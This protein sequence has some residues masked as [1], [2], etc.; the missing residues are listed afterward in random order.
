MSEKVHFESLLAMA[1]NEISM[2]LIET[3]PSHEEIKKIYAASD[4]F[5]KKKEAWIRIETRKENLI[6]F[7]RRASKVAVIVLL[8]FSLSFSTLLTAKAVRESIVTTVLEWKDKFTRIFIES[9]VQ[10]AVLPEIKFNY[11]P[12]GFELI[13]NQTHVLQ[14]SVTFT[15]EN[16]GNELFRIFITYDFASYKD[17]LDNE[18]SSFY[19]IKINIK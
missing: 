9:D 4:S 18:D 1:M 16:A 12:D 11:I 3:I 10:I 17:R 5:L 6:K 2:D 14:S 7:N 15:Y 13:E 19:N 8:A